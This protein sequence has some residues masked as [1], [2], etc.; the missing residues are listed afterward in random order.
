[1]GPTHS[2]TLLARSSE[3]WAV[4]SALARADLRG[5]LCHSGAGAKATP[6]TSPRCPRFSGMPGL[7]QGDAPRDPSTPRTR[8]S[9]LFVAPMRCHC[10]R[11]AS[12]FLAANGLR[13]EDYA[14]PNY[15][16]QV[17]GISRQAPKHEGAPVGHA[18]PRLASCTHVLWNRLDRRGG[19]RRLGTSGRLQVP[20]GL[21]T[22]RLG[23][24]HRASHFSNAGLAR[25]L[26][27]ERTAHAL[28]RSHLNRIHVADDSG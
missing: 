25:L 28:P 10:A 9:Q 24:S 3:L 2:G 7:T 8:A 19:D 22:G 26:H 21:L 18:A 11:P 15:T 27:G 14:A 16:G 4:C 12:V 1:L 17:L 13:V 5:H 23:D 20:C 6:Q